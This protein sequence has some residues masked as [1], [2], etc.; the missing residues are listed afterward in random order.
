MADVIILIFF[1]IL[2]AF[3]RARRDS[4]RQ[5]LNRPEE[6]YYQNYAAQR[7]KVAEAEKRIARND[8]ITALEQARDYL[9]PYTDIF[10]SLTLLNTQVR[11]VLNAAEKSVFCM[12]RIPN[13]N[14]TQ[15]YFT[16][17]NFVSSNN[18][19]A[20][21]NILCRNFNEKTTYQQVL[22]SCA[23]VS[24]IKLSVIED[25]KIKAETPPLP[26]INSCSEAE[27][28]NLPGI[29]VIM[30]KKI[31][32][33]RNTKRPFLSAQDLFEI[34][35]IPAHFAQQLENLICVNKVDMEEYKKKNKKSKGKRI[36]DF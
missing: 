23:Q 31:I 4:P 24:V 6:N 33:F 27:I 22:E 17:K 28:S 8:R 29:N 34:M 15:R 13:E 11:V 21:W 10:G 9:K 35:N 5:I 7:N 25:P 20:Y 32:N 18:I 3:L 12:S 26:D 2:A 30:A 19:D 14:G 16:A 36:I 1:V